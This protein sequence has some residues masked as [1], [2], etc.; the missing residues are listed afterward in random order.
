MASLCSIRVCIHVNN[1]SN[2]AQ[3]R[4]VFFKKD[5]S[6]KDENLFNACRSVHSY[7]PQSHTSEVPQPKV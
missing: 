3:R 6:I 4:A 2:K 5:I 1:F 7:I